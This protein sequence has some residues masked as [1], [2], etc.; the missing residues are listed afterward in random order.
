MPRSE[1]ELKYAH[2]EAYKLSL[3]MVQWPHS[4]HTADVFEAMHAMMSFQRHVPA[5]YCMIQE[6]DG[7]KKCFFLP[8]FKFNE[9]R[10]AGKLSEYNL[11]YTLSSYHKPE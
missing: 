11:L 10:S 6:C 3:N 5:T 8:S 4:C 2:A 1:A 9:M 7:D